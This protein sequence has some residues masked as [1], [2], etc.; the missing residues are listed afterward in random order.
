MKF[1]ISTQCSP[2]LPETEKLV[3]CFNNFCG[4]ARASKNVMPLRDF[5][6]VICLARK[7]LR[8]RARHE[9]FRPLFTLHWAFVISPRKTETDEI[10]RPNF[11]NSWTLPMPHPSPHSP[12]RKWCIGHFSKLPEC[13]DHMLYS[14]T[15]MALS[16]TVLII[17][18]WTEFTCAVSGN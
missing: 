4:T 12:L 9:L 6:P 7:K 10:I 18:E 11:Q 2:V 14:Y 15:A 16:H 17:V 1:E 8:H 5:D 3:F 13:S